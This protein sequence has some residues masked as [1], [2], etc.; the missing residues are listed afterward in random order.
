MSF[1]L[2]RWLLVASWMGAGHQKDHAMNRSLE[3]SAPISHLSPEKRESQN[4]IN[5]RSCL[6]GVV[7]I[8]TPI[9][10]GSESVWVGETSMCQEGG[11]PSFSGTEAPA[12]DTSRLHPMYLYSWCSSLSFIIISFIINQWTSESVS[13]SSV[14]IIANYWTQGGGHGN[15]DL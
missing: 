5:V 1:V 8:N 12:P 9:I 13:L 4:G 14:T 15:P 11:T 2:M 7:F 6:C 10:Q 3:I